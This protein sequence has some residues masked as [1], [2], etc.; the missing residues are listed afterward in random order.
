MR[1]PQARISVLYDVLNDLGCDA[2]IKPHKTAETQMA[3]DHLDAAEPGDLILCDRGYAGIFW[4]ILQQSRGQEFV[5]RCSKGSFLAVQELFKRDQE[6]VSCEVE[7][8]A[9]ADM[10]PRLRK[11]GLKNKIRVR[12]ITLRLNT[13]ELEVLATSLLDTKVYP[14]EEFADLY[15]LRWGIETYYHRLKARLDLE[16]WTG[17]TKISI[18]QDFQAA[19]F[20]SNLES[21][22]SEPAEEELAQATA[23]RKHQTQLNRA[24]G[25]HTIKHKILE[26]LAGH[27]PVNQVLKELG[28]LFKANPVCVRPNRKVPRRETPTG[29][30][31]QFQRN[32]RKIVF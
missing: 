31:Y 23:H 11:A 27:K 9:A 6:G 2:L 16:N 29:Q 10:K 8:E 3:Q 15:H 12:L 13:G 19:V 1:F 4:F 22:I 28:V 14:T 5:V 32:V 21:V 30:A 7:L 18:L 24:V 26:L 25:F 20:L 17:K